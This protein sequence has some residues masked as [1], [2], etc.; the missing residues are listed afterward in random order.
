MT[1]EKMERAKRL[2]IAREGWNFKKVHA[3]AEGRLKYD[4]HDDANATIVPPTKENKVNPLTDRTETG[5][6]ID[7]VSGTPK[8]E[9]EIKEAEEKWDV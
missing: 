4:E 3:M 6:I 5:L 1:T 7:P 9:N 8:T 2:L